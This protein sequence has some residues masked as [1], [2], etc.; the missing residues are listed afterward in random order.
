M[1]YMEFD[2]RFVAPPPFIQMMLET[3]SETIL[4]S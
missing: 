4:V 1:I 2:A 3:P